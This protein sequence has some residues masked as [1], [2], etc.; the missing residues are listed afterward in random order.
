MMIKLKI[1]Q[2]FFIFSYGKDLNI[3]VTSL[4]QTKFLLN[5]QLALQ[6]SSLGRQPK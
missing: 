1:Q 6:H 3:L 5:T 2:Y 4:I